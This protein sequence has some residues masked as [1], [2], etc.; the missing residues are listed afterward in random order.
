M[1]LTIHPQTQW[2]PEPGMTHFTTWKKV[3]AALDSQEDNKTLWYIVSMIV[4]GVLFLSVPAAL[5]YYFY[6]PLFILPVTLVLF[7]GNIIAGMGG[8]GIRVILSLFIISA[9]VHLSLLAFY[10][11]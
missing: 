3:L 4:Q 2:N 10:L 1:E 11:L 8:A 5:I 6:A 7:F 9:I